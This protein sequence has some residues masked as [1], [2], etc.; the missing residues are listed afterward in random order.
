MINENNPRRENQSKE[1]EDQQKVDQKIREGA[2]TRTKENESGE[3]KK[4]DLPDSSND[5]DM[6]G[7]GSGQRQ[8][9]N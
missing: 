8:D 2:G 3:L 5:K 9:S 4:E 1:K 7:M 6:G